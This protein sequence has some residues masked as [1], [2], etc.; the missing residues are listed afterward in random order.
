M[1]NEWLYSG[2]GDVRLAEVLNADLRL[3]LADRFSLMGHPSIY[4]AGS[5]ASSGS[6]TIKVGFA[7]L[8]G[9]DR[10]APVAEN[11]SVA[12]TAVTDTSVTI[13]IARQALQRQISD[14]N[15]MA[16]SIGLDL[17]ALINDG[18]GAYAMRWME[19]LCDLID[20]FS[21][22]VGTT[23]VD[24]T[25][26]DFFSA[27][28][29][30]MQASVP[31]PYLSILHNVQLTDLLNDLRGESGP[32][33]YRNDVQDIFTA[34]GQGI[35][36]SLNGIDIVSSTLV[37]TANAGAD[38]AG[39]MFGSGAVGYADGTPKAIRG[40]GGLVYPAGSK[41]YTELE[42]DASGALTKA[43]HNSFMGWA[44]LEDARGVTI[45]SDR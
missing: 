43:V 36:G 41:M 7:S 45:I 23:T 28:F 14:L 17:Q 1:A 21:S 6:T 11:A 40:A 39:A 32:W 27:Q 5:A 9:V 35:S 33:Q 18:V 8:N 16:D 12:N 38:S 13:T 42:R 24:M 10:M 3:S 20:G 44:E 31:P 29:T 19:M 30:L 4:Y 37:P 2:A 26:D 34:K 22:T 15:E 25:T